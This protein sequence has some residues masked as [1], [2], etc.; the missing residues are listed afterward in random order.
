MNALRL[1]I[2]RLAMGLLGVAHLA[3][4][5]A[6]TEVNV[7]KIKEQYT[8]EKA[9]ILS[10]TKSVDIRVGSGNQLI[11]TGKNS[12]EKLFLTDQANYFADEY[13]PHS[14]FVEVD[15]IEAL[16]LKPKRN[17]KRFDKIEIDHI[18]TED[19]YDNWVFYDD[20]QIKKIIFPKV[21]E[22]YRSLVTYKETY[23]DPHFLGGF[24]F[25]SYMPLVH[26]QYSVEFPKNVMLRFKVFNDE[27]E[28]VQFQKDELQDRIRYTWK[29]KNKKKY[30]LSYDD[31]PITHYEPHILIYI[32]HYQVDSQSILVLSDLD[33]LYDW[34]YQHVKDVNRS[35]TPA[36]KNLVDSLTSKAE[37]EIEKIK[38]IYYWVQD[39]IN[40]VAMESGYEGFVPKSAAETFKTRYGDCKGMSSILVKMLQMAGM[41]AKFAWIGT[42]SVHYRHDD[43]PLPNLHNHMIA[44][45]KQK[46]DYIIMDP[47]SS[48]LPLGMASSFIQGQEAMI[49]VDENHYELY[50]IPVQNNQESVYSDTVYLQIAEGAVKGNG[51]SRLSGYYKYDLAYELNWNNPSKHKEILKNWF[52]KNNDKFS[53]DTFNILNLKTRDTCLSVVYDFYIPDYA[54]AFEDAYYVNLNLDK[55]R[56]GKNIDTG[57]Y[58]YHKKID[59]KRIKEINVVLKM[60]DNYTIEELPKGKSVEYPE[61]GFCSKY[62]RKGNEIWLRKRY[63]VNVLSVENRKFDQ[64]NQ[65]VQEI[66][67]VYN[68]SIVLRKKKQKE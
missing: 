48:Y 24:Y 32:D 35:A 40:Y 7:Q 8:E 18:Y 30:P 4:V 6:Q 54:H 64:W 20:D 46:D 50:H 55:D 61:F 5:N 45:V 13:I 1:N 37:S 57:E 26:A 38:N 58:V 21:D 22:N 67:K 51:K 27:N 56:F 36:L 3:G 23:N 29:I 52:D 9:V 60:P 28:A 34:Y 53:L 11:I 65:M 47:T 39:H 15:D 43:I 62:E 68:Q 59:Y 66:D 33:E 42:R 10:K 16:L 49:G 25:S 14:T 12:I 63:Y 2:V 19:T 44:A 17:G 31:F 41:D